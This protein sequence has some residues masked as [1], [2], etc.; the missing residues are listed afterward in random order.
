MLGTQESVSRL[1][2]VKVREGEFRSNK[3]TEVVPVES[4][5]LRVLL[6]LQHSPQKL[7]IPT[8]LFMPGLVKG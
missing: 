7:C 8:N 5:A 1:A 3:A 6:Y 4:K 2:D